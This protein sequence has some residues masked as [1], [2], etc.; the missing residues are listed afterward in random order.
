[1]V[2]P[3]ISI[4]IASFI[5]LNNISISFE[6]YKLI[7]YDQEEE[8]LDPPHTGLYRKINKNYIEYLYRIPSL[9]KTNHIK[10]RAHFEWVPQLEQE[11]Y[12]LVW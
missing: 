3:D 5:Y 2:L 9:F 6:P 1:M 8:K 10:K 4:H 12:C 7:A 11:P